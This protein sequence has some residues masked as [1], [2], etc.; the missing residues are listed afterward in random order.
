MSEQIGTCNCE[1]VSPDI[2]N[3]ETQKEEGNGGG[4]AGSSGGQGEEEGNGRGTAGSSGERGDQTEG[5]ESRDN[6]MEEVPEEEEEE[7]TRAKVA[8]TPNRISQQELEHS[9]VEHSDG[10]K[11]FEKLVQ[12]EIR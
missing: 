7:T 3:T 12:S 9:H 4:A 10:H 2:L 8:T 6:R 11:E 5:Q 1:S